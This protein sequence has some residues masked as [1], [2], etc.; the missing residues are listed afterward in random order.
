MSSVH[1]IGVSIPRSGHHYLARILTSYLGDACFYCEFYNPE[2]CCRSVPCLKRDAAPVVFQKNHDFKLNLDTDVPGA[3]YLIQYRTPVPATLSHR[4]MVARNLGPELAA[5]ERNLEVWLAEKAAYYQ[6]FF[7]RWVMP[8]NAR[9]LKL[10]YDLLTR[11]TVSVVA[12]VL[13]RSG[14]TVDRSALDAVVSEESGRRL[15]N[16]R[17]KFK[18]RV[19]EDSPYFHP[20]LL[21][22]FE[23]LVISRVPVLEEKRQLRK[24]DASGSRLAVTADA[25]RAG[26]AGDGAASVRLFREA[27]GMGDENPFLLEAYARA[28]SRKPRFHDEARDAIERAAALLPDSASIAAVR[29]K[30]S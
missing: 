29:R 10:D 9:F 8:R 23:S 26:F 4:E 27:A 22:L 13:E 2:D 3:C 6:G 28:A 15:A 25:F 16:R 24:V 19:L 12:D 11:E 20:S 14:L 30:L 17:G 21:E 18:P 5:D 1:F 7:E